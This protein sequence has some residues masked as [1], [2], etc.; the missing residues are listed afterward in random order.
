MTSSALGRDFRLLWSAAVSSRF[1]DA[2]RTPALALL[3]ATV[4][5]DPRIIAAVTV[6]GQLP[7]LLFGLLGGVYADRW[8]RRRTMAVV[9]GVRAAVVAA[10]AVVVALNRVSVLVL[11]VAAFLLATLGT[12]FDSASFAL[13]P[14]LV[15]PDALPRANGRLQAGSAVAGG[16]LGAPAAGVLFAVAP[17]LPFALDA[18]TFAAAALLVLALSPPLAITPGTARRRG[19]VWS[20]IVEGLRWLRAHRTLWRVTLLTAASNLAISGI[21]AVLVLYA[22]DVL[23]VPPAG[24]GLFTAAAIVGGVAGALGAGRL[25]AR[26]G[27]VPALRA[28]L[29]VET[30]AL[31]GF[32]LARHPVSGGI[33]LAVFAAGTVVWNSLWASYGQR[34]VPSEL[35]GRVGAAQRMVGLL[36]APLGAALA[37]LAAAAYGTAPVAGAAAATFALVTGAAW[38]TLRPTAPVVMSRAG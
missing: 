7:P 18:V 23:R 28:V 1:G 16:F 38:R 21:M 22:L 24:Y 2:L 17:A 31:T 12:L 8:D 9:D 34:Q 13:L 37:G 33:A 20:E 10:L 4:T 5:R 14:A 6:V 29:A 36:T 32:A 30:V 11:L 15:P 35:L 3:A 19:S 25:A 26:L 27:T